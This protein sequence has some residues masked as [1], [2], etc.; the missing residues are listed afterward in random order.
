MGFSVFT[1]ISELYSIE[2]HVTAFWGTH[3]NLL[4]F[5]LSSPMANDPAVAVV[6]NVCSTEC[7]NVV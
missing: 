2:L 6:W 4:L 3:G 1:S 5:V 7:E